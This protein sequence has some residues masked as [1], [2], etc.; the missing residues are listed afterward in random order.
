MPIASESDEV[1]QESL[2]VRANLCTLTCGRGRGTSLGVC[3]HFS[4]MPDIC[5]L[6]CSIEA[7]LL[8]FR[9]SWNQAAIP[10]CDHLCKPLLEQVVAIFRQGGSSCHVRTSI[11]DRDSVH[12]LPGSPRTGQS[13]GYSP[14][15]RQIRVRKHSTPILRTRLWGSSW[16]LWRNRRS[17][18]YVC[19]R[20]V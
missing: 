17:E 12:L 2:L 4:I 7:S 9:C 13:R 3:V 20:L 16:G 14:R 5:R 18:M 19:Q 6:S 11:L 1:G 8:L 15:C 10:A